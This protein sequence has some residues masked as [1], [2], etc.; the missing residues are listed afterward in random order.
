LI[1]VFRFTKT[2]LGLRKTEKEIIPQTSEINTM[3]RKAPV[4]ADR[5]KVTTTPVSKLVTTNSD[6]AFS[7][8]IHRQSAAEK[9][10]SSGPDLDA[11]HD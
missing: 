4:P 3:E 8:S 7:H 10:R 11:C 9:Q 2:L 5:D 6:V 1:Y